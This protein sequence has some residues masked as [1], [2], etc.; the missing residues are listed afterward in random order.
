[1]AR[2]ACDTSA[3]RENSPL[4]S[5]QQGYNW[6]DD[7]GASEG[8]LSDNITNNLIGCQVGFE[9]GY[10]RRPECGCSS[11]ENRHLRQLSGRHLPGV[12]GN[13]INGLTPYGY[14]PVHSTQNGVAFISQVDLAPNG[15]SR[16]TAALGWATAS[17]PSP[18]PGW[19]T[20][21]S[22][23]TSSTSPKSPTFST[24]VAWCCTDAF[25]GLT[26]RF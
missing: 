12:S 14:F 8:Y 22:P 24:T 15:S 11:A 1:M 18:A 10:R 17:W 25:A 26:Y 6:G 13:G 5:L 9:L 16:E 19:P 3:S 4:P 21:K 7:N 23:S 20:T 2:W